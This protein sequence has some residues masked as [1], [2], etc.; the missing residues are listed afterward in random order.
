MVD[1]AGS[2]NYA[3][4][5]LYKPISQHNAPQPLLLVSMLYLDFGVQIQQVKTH[6]LAYSLFLDFINK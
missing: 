6:F 3:I 1:V 4:D 2:V 5:I